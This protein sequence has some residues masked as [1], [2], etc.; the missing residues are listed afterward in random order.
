MMPLYLTSDPLMCKMFPSSLGTLGLVLF[1]KFASKS[2]KSFKYLSA[3][4]LTRF[5]TNQK[6]P[7]DIDTLISLR[8]MTYETLKEYSIHY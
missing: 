3:Q 5:G 2:V 4:F 7:K 8:K 6:E 1:N